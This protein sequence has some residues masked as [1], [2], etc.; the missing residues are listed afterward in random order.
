MIRPSALSAALL[1]AALSLAAAP[2]AAQGRDT[3]A[4][5][6]P[7]H[8]HDGA[9]DHAAAPAPADTAF[10]RLQER[11]R[12]AMGV[13]QYTSRHLFESLS[14][15][16][17]IELQRVEADSAGTAT[18]RAHLQGIARAFRAGDFGTPAFVHLRE[19]PG[20]AAMAA[21]R[22][23]ITYTYRDLPRGGELRMRTDDIKA[24]VAIHEFMAFQRS[25][26]R[27]DP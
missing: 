4:A 17:R 11:G 1:L 21:R 26:H 19:V 9:H 8:A 23:A 16:G 6:A 22:A 2:L 5:P 10:A 24:R 12:S 15:G 14:D 25:E 13:D 3:A 18:I 27:T 20:A 7:T